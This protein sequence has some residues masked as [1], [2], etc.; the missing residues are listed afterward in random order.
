[1]GTKVDRLYLCDGKAC[2]KEKRDICIYDKLD[3]I[4]WS[5]DTRPRLL[6]EHTSNPEHSITNKLSTSIEKDGFDPTFIIDKNMPNVE[7]EI[8]D[9]SLIQYSIPR[10]KTRTT[11]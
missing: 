7:F 6:C 10:I 5:T 1:M 3:S 8:L 11:L 2:P 9:Q 4:D